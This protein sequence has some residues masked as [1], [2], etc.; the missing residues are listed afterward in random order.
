M[1]SCLDQ[2]QSLFPLHATFHALVFQQL[3]AGAAEVLKPTSVRKH[4]DHAW[5]I[6]ETEC[7]S[8][9]KAF[10]LSSGVFHSSFFSSSFFL[11]FSSARGAVLGAQRNN[12]YKVKRTSI[13]GS[14]SIL[15]LT[16]FT[17]HVTGFNLFMLNVVPKTGVPEIFQASSSLSSSFANPLKRFSSIGISQTSKERGGGL[18]NAKIWF[19]SDSSI[20]PESVWGPACRCR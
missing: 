19:I 12:K 18:E 20:F 13:W 5:N 15:Q 9:R 3:A 8:S 14:C 2:L 4:T 17:L 6:T 11:S 16:Q 7:L 1:I 10:L